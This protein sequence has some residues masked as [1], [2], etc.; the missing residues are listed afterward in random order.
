[1][2]KRQ[3]ELP[4]VYWDSGAKGS[5]YWIQLNGQLFKMDKKEAAEHLLDTEVLD[6][7]FGKMCHITN[8]DRQFLLARVERRVDY[9]GNLGGWRKGTHTLPNGMKVLIATESR[10]FSTKAE[11]RKVPPK[12]IYKFLQ[13]LFGDEQLPYVMA[14]LKMARQS[15][16]AGNWMPGPAQ[17]LAGDSGCGKTFYQIFVTEFLGGRAGSPYKYMVGKEGFNDDLAENEHLI[18]SDQLASTNTTA[19]RAFGN[20]IK[21]LIA[22]AEMRVRAL[23]HKPLPLIATFRRLTISCNSEPENLM[24]VPPLD[25]SM[26]DKISLFLCDRAELAPADQREKNLE[27]FKELPAFYGFLEQWRIPE[28]IRQNSDDVKRYGFDRWHHP[29]LRATL[30][31]TQDEMR[32]LEMIDGVLF[33]DGADEP[34]SGPAHELEE[35]LYA[36]KFAGPAHGLLNKWTGFC[37]TC[38]SRLKVKY[39]HRFECRKSQ[40]KTRWHIRAPEGEK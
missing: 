11:P 26:Q 38:L 6:D 2:T 25:T 40:G 12:R 36:S 28:S 19:R 39:P 21:D 14:W 33:A 17:V 16:L 27:M 31:S 18:V 30:E 1:M 3:K 10:V 4:L 9:A 29:E 23:Y 8:I 37:G 32:L 22:N 15:L 7:P 13:E 24:I 34:W 5:G 20:A 35:R